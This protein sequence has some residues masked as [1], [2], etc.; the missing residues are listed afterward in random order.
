MGLYLFEDSVIF[1]V[2]DEK[3]RSVP[4]GA[5]G[6]KLL[7]TVLSSRAQPLI[8]YELSDSVRLAADTGSN[9]LPF[10]RIDGIQELT[11]DI[12]HLSGVLSG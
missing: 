12:L 10:A 3:N 5:F 6:A 2:V 9:S 1:E 11:E 8:R 7:I 4:A